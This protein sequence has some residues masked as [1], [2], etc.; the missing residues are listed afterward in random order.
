MEYLFSRTHKYSIKVQCICDNKLRIRHVV[1]GNPGSV[2]DAK[3]FKN[4]DVFKEP[5]KYFSLHQWIAGDSAY[6]LSST[7]ITPYRINSN[8]MDV[9]K[10][11][12]FNRRHS[13]YRVRIEHC[14]G[15]L[16]EKFNSLKG[17]KMRINSSQSHLFSCQW[18]VVCCILH[19]ILLD[20][21]G[22]PEF[23]Q[24][25]EIDEANEQQ[26]EE[27]QD[28]NSTNAKFEFKRQAIYSLLF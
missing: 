28:T 22:V 23:N 20:G 5:E 15:M 12:Q 16:I 6:S 21:P 4:C 3:I 9:Q 1:V 7:L 8:Q 13:K 26:D 19:N 14:F 11:K 17:L 25:H 27:E 10:R 24:L 18:I 2:H